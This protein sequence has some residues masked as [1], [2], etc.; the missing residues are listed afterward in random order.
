MNE[1][2]EFT[3][4]ER[5]NPRVEVVGFTR[6]DF[7]LGDGVHKEWPTEDLNKRW[8]GGGAQLDADITERFVNVLPVEA[9]RTTGFI[10]LGIVGLYVLGSLLKLRPLKLGSFT[11]FYPAPRLVIQQLIIGPIELLG[12]AGI[13]Y[14]ALPEVGN[15]GFMVILGIFLISFSAALISHAPGG[16]FLRVRLA[17]GGDSLGQS[18]FKSGQNQG[19]F[20]TRPY[21]TLL[22]GAC[23]PSPIRLE[24]GRG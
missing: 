9:S 10:L 15:P 18:G 6:E 23:L 5:R 21:K 7:W 14:Y 4:D 1:H 8:F 11:L 19:G 24:R 2:I 22:D 12:A 13:I 3:P 17:R 16:R 20:T